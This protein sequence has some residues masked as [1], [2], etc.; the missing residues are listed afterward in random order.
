MTIVVKKAV[1]HHIEK[2]RNETP[3]LRL[4]DRTHPHSEELSKFV[5]E[6]VNNST[7]NRGSSVCKIFTQDDTF[8]Q[9]YV[10]HFIKK[11]EEAEE[12]EETFISFSKE[13][14][15]S[16]S[17]HM[18]TSVFTTGG[19]I[20]ILH[21]KKDEVEYI[22]IA[23]V[24]PESG[25]TINESTGVVES[26]THISKEA[27]RFA[28]NV[29]ISNLIA[30]YSLYASGTTI[31]DEDLENIASY[32]FWT[33]KSKE[34]KLSDYF[35]NFLPVYRRIDDTKSTKNTHEAIKKYLK[36]RITDEEVRSD[37]YNTIVRVLYDKASNHEIVY[38]DEDIL[39][40]I[41]SFE[42]QYPNSFDNSISK[43]STFCEEQDL[44]YQG[45]FSPN[46]DTV[47]KYV[48]FKNIKLG[49]SIKFSGDTKEF[50]KKARIKQYNHAPS[51]LFIDLTEEDERALLSEF[52][53][54]LLVPDSDF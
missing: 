40:I 10:N 3:N 39:T 29:N 2:K 5:T 12:A 47:E 42:I 30:H 23:V 45:S 43:F 34:T 13:L 24:T 4:R 32:A 22:M 14:V 27:I 8:A 26:I 48:K 25:V 52:G 9:S 31:D 41:D 15:A 54:T 20:P 51:R 21:Y 37:T 46:K 1:I 18:I 36:V 33:Q 35:Q 44:P 38:L 50:K 19:N 16:L 17:Q 28:L 7:V 6:V 11:T 53:E 49:N